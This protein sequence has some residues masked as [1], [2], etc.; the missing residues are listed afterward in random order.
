[1]KIKSGLKYCKIVGIALI[2]LLCTLSFG[3]LSKYQSSVDLPNILWI[4]SEDNSAC[5]TGC[6]GNRFSTTPNIDKLASEGFLNTH[7]Y[8]PNTVCAP[9][10]NTILTGIY[11]GKRK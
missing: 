1:M 5:F 3:K 11:I 2:I 4:V 6:Y 10:R 8:C 9:S 7:A